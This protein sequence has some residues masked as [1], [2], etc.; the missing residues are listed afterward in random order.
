MSE[1]AFRQSIEY[2]RQNE[3]PVIALEDLSY[4]CED[5]DYGKVMNRRLHA[6]AFAR[7]QDRIEDKATEAGIHVECVNVAYTSNTCHACNHLDRRDE[8]AEFV[9]PHDDY[10]VSELRRGGC[11]PINSQ[12]IGLIATSS[13]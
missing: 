7:L 13:F 11:L 5:L 4:I 10:H 6:W 2:A 1:K 9:C 12:L 3:N 8:Q